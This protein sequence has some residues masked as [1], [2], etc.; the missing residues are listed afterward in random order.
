MIYELVLA[1][2]EALREYVALHVLTCLVPAFL[3]AGAIVTF[4]SKDV[5]LKY[6]GPGARKIIAFPFAAFSGIFLAV[7]SC[8]VI[9][10]SAGIY[11]R[12]GGV[13]PA[14]ILL[15]TAPATNIL[16]IIY[17]GAI[18]G[19]DMAFVRIIAALTTA[20]IVGLVMAYIFRGERKNPNN[21]GE[22]QVFL[23][24]KVKFLEYKD[25]TLLILL[26]ASLLL[27]NY[28]VV[29]GPYLKKVLVFLAGI[30]VV[31]IYALYTKE[32]EEIKGWLQETWWFV[33]IIFPLLLVGVFLIG[34]IGKILP[35][36]WISTWLGGNGIF[37]SFLASLIGAISYF[38]TLTEAPF[39]DTLM[40]LGMGKGPALSLLLAGP[41]LSFPNMLAIGRVYGVRKTGFYI[42]TVVVL[43]TLCG[44]V[45]GNLIF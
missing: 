12:G 44:F 4:L 17:T 3:L 40:G 30:T 26:I 41:G 8:T 14:F 29:K 45:A 5:I 20:T 34:I 25:A 21:P 1:G 11:Q 42:I 38:A 13:G 16:A 10:I 36:A 39:V 6:L 32:R 7:C 22:T 31:A 2:F 33:K 19:Y 23:S 9:P 27:P 28:L 18:L 24:D 15:W 37:A 35:E 43:A